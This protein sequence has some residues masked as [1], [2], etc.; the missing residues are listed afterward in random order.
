MWSNLS[1]A[2]VDYFIR[3][4]QLSIIIVTGNRL[5]GLLKTLFF[6]GKSAYPP[7]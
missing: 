2:M 6:F 5:A 1:F 7:I 3:G 4:T